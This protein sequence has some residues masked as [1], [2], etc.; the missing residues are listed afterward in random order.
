M[1]LTTQTRLSVAQ[2]LAVRCYMM[3][4][5]AEGMWA[6]PVRRRLV[7]FIIGQRLDQVNIFA[8]VF[9]EG[10]QGLRLGSNIS[11]NRGCNLSCF[12]GLVIGN[13]V[14]IGHDCSIIT[15]EH[16]FADV[17]IP[18]QKQPSSFAPV[19]IADNVWLGAKVVVLA[20]VAIPTGTVVAAAAV[21]TRSIE[22]PDSI[23][24]GVPAKRI[25]SRFD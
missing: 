25:K 13:H 15:S 5:R 2:K 21:I 11:F 17:S 12:G 23:F 18:I 1:T 24:A 8:H 3:L 22:Q 16:G 9:I 4:I 19:T 7:G 14:S 6:L 10:W 20:G